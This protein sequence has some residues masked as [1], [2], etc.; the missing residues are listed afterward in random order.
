MF[1]PFC[2]CD[3]TVNTSCPRHPDTITFHFFTANLPHTKVLHA[4][5]HNETLKDISP[6]KH[7]VIVRCIFV[8][9]PELLA[10]SDDVCDV[11]T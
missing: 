1:V 11:H 7:R 2:V 6:S 4:P 8:D 5:P 9:N 10:V 3:M